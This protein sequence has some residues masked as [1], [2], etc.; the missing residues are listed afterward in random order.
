[1]GAKFAPRWSAGILAK[2][3]LQLVHHDF[4]AERTGLSLGEEWNAVAT[5][6]LADKSLLTLKVADYDGP[7]RAPAPADRTK[8]WL[9]LEYK[10]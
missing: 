7:D 10:I 8:A 9:M 4:T 2:P 5:M 3:T 1:V 6:R